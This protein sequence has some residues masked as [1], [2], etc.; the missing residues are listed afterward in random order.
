[1][2][3]SK[4]L[5]NGINEIPELYIIG[6]PV[7]SVFSFTS[8]KI[9]IYNFITPGYYI[10]KIFTGFY[11]V[12]VYLFPNYPNE[13]FDYCNEKFFAIGFGFTNWFQCY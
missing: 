9:D 10:E 13:G 8:D 1:M 5:I 12:H 7:M 3:A 6:K 2:D 11:M 4:K